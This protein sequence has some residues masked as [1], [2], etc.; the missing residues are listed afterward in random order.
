MAEDNFLVHHQNKMASK[1]LGFIFLVLKMLKNV[2]KKIKINQ[3][4][5]QTIQ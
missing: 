3:N 4:L 5:M 2:I 1:L